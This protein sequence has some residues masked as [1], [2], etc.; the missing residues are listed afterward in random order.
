MKPATKDAYKLF[1]QGSVA[2]AEI[3]AAG[4]PISAEKLEASHA[5]VD[6]SIHELGRKLKEH[7]VFRLQ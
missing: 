5:S 2:L 7:E 4:L 6:Q 3:E 1:L